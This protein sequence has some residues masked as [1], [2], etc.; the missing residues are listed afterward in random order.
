MTVTVTGTR[1]SVHAL[2]VMSIYTLSSRG[3]ESLRVKGACA[4]VEVSK[5]EVSPVGSI[6]RDSEHF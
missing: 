4:T 2:V 1:A 3:A 5:M 6:P